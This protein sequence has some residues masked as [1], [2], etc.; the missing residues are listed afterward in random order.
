MVLYTIPLTLSDTRI[1][2]ES[3]GALMVIKSSANVYYIS[4]FQFRLNCIVLET[5]G[6][7]LTQHW[8]NVS[9]LLGAGPN[10]DLVVARNSEVIGFKSRPD[11]GCAYTVL[12]TVQRSGVC[13]AVYGTVHYKESLKSFDKSRV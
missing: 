13:S 8:F 10:A 1:M 11:R 12:Q 6:P 7:A 3:Q 2:S 5:G 9:C 4:I